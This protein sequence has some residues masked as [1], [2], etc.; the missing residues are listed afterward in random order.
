MRQDDRQK[1]NIHHVHHARRKIT[2]AAAAVLGEGAQQQKRVFSFPSPRIVTHTRLAD[3]MI[4]LPGSSSP[5]SSSS[6]R[7]G[8]RARWGSGCG[9]AVA[10]RSG[11]RKGSSGRRVSGAPAARG[12]GAA[13]ARSFL[14]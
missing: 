11:F 4:F 10:K 12:S 6:I 3:G 8:R 2:R 13:E 1:L 7:G 14:R 5:S 9:G